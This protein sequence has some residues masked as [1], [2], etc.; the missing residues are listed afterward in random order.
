MN[1][2]AY[3]RNQHCLRRF[4]E[5][6]ATFVTGLVVICVVTSYCPCPLSIWS[7]VYVNG[8]SSVRLSVCLSRGSRAATAAGGFAAE[9]TTL[10]APCCSGGAQQQMRVAF[11]AMLRPEGGG[12]TQTCIS[13]YHFAA[14]TICSKVKYTGIAVRSVTHHYGNSHAIWDHT[15]VTATRQRWRARRYPSRSWYSIKRHQRDARLS[16]PSWLVTYRDGLHAR[17][18]SPIQVLTG[19]D[20]G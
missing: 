7:K 14:D 5:G 1:G 18:R 10:R 8:R 16:W 20:V 4:C 6:M 9:R 19:P 2:I 3:S 15:V 11:G 13:S 17:R 12:S